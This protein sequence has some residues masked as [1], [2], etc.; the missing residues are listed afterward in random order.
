[1]VPATIIG[2]VVT[3]EGAAPFELDTPSGTVTTGRYGRADPDQGLMGREACGAVER[4]V[5]S[6]LAGV[7]E[8][9]VGR[10]RCPACGA[11]IDVVRR[12]KDWS[13]TSSASC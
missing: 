8:V 11:W 9:R 10:Y 2:T 3:A 5:R 12:P 13:G 7:V 4:Q 1:M 6:Q